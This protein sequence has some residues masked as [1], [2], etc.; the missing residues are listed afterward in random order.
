MS[1]TS[2]LPLW[3]AIP[4]ALAC[5]GVAGYLYWVVSTKK[6][7]QER[8]PFL[9]GAILLTLIGVVSAVLAFMRVVRK[10]KAKKLSAPVRNGVAPGTVLFGSS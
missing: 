8:A 4:F 5:F 3:V 10:L 7:R 6:T 2:L 9:A 1:T